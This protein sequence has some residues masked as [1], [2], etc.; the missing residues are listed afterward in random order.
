M[1]RESAGG[2]DAI[3]SFGRDRPP[4]STAAENPVRRFADQWRDRYLAVTGMWERS[5][6]EFAPFLS[7]PADIRKLLG[8]PGTLPLSTVPRCQV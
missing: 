5:W 2:E 7:V 6:P 3:G 8:Q 4:T 1:G